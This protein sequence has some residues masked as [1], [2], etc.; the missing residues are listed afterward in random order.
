MGSDRVVS[1]SQGF[2]LLHPGLRSVTLFEGYSVSSVPGGF[3]L[4]YIPA[5]HSG[6]CFCVDC[7]HDDF[8]SGCPLHTDFMMAEA[9]DREALLKQAEL[10]AGFFLTT[11]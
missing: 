2:A 7:S 4:G 11:G 3:T 1:V 9:Y 10:F 5:P 8:V 6:F